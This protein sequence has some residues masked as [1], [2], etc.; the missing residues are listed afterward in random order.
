MTDVEALAL[1][2]RR[3]PM[4]ALAWAAMADA[5]EESG[6][7]DSFDR[8]VS[9]LLFRHPDGLPPVPRVVGLV[10]GDVSWSNIGGDV[11]MKVV[12]A[13]GLGRYRSEVH[14]YGHTLYRPEEKS[15]WRIGGSVETWQR[16]ER[17]AGLFVV[18]PFIVDPFMTNP[19]RFFL[20]SLWARPLI[21]PAGPPDR[22]LLLVHPALLPHVVEGWGS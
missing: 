20:V 13:H 5:K 11:P 9:T 17:D 22:R 12:V 8:A 6:G 18:D 16:A 3:D 2:L 21:D 14:L 15:L 1:A 10:R 19:Q 4:D 7:G